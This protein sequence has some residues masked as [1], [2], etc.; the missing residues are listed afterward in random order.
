LAFFK[1]SST[2]LLF[3]GQIRVG[4]TIYSKIRVTNRRYGFLCDFRNQRF[5]PNLCGLRR[6]SF[7]G[8]ICSIFFYSGVADK[9]CCVHLSI[10]FISCTIWSISALCSSVRSSNH[11]GGG[12]KGG[13]YSADFCIIFVNVFT[14]N[15]RSLGS[16]LLS[17]SGRHGWRLFHCPC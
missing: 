16:R 15:T 12:P 7:T 6:R 5:L 10:A 11:G 17:R 8:R 14:V 1:C 4:K 2:F 3:A 9:G 13:P